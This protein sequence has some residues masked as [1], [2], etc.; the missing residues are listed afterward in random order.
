MKPTR[1]QFIF[2]GTRLVAIAGLA[3]SM[4]IAPVAASAANQDKHED[5]AEMR[6]KDLHG[7]LKITAEE[8]PLW[9]QVAQV[10]RDDAKTMDALTQARM[11]HAK[12]VSAVDDI[13]SYGEIASAHADGIKKLLPVFTTLYTSMSDSQKKEADIL[14]RHGDNKRGHKM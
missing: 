12:D 14:F 10:M 11:D 7:K 4:A 6:I 13:R 8:E 5:R 9:N 2:A 3:L 1:N